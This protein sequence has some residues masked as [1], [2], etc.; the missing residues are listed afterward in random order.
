M[1][2]RCAA[3]ADAREGRIFR[4]REFDAVP[5]SADKR[6]ARFTDRTSILARTRR[7]T[8]WSKF[9]PIVR[10]GGTVTAGNASG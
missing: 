8:V 7:W 2:L 9:K 1:S 4:A 6:D 3:S 5:D 10:P